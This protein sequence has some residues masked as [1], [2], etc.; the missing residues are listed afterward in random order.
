[1]HARRVYP[2]STWAKMLRSRTF[3]S[4]IR[5]RV[6]RISLAAPLSYAAVG[7]HHDRS[8]TLLRS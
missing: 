6:P 1:M 2:R 8:E 4:H 5:H 3:P 7:F